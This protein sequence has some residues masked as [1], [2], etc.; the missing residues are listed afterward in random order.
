ML[1][2]NPLSPG[3]WLMRRLRL[4][5]KLGLLAAVLLVPLT[6][7]CVLLVQR[8]GGDIEF[9]QGETEGTRTLVHLAQVV[10]AVQTHRGQTQMLLAE[11]GRASCRERV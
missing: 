4:P 3:V 11:I 7:L 8:L 2:I 5:A 10:Q 1:S 6:V 9:A